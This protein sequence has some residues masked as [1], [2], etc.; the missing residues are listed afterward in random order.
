MTTKVKDAQV[1]KK[2]GGEL[3]KEALSHELTNFKL[4]ASSVASILDPLD[5][6]IEHY[7]LFVSVKDVPKGIRHFNVRGANING[8]LYKKVIADFMDRNK[9]FH[10]NNRGIIILAESVTTRGKTV[11][12]DLGK[13]GGIMDGGRTDKIIQV[14]GADAP[15]NQFV[16]IQIRVG[17]PESKQSG[18]AVGL[19][20]SHQV[21]LESIMNF[22]KKFDDIKNV[23]K[24]Q[25][26]AGDISW[27]ESTKRQFK[28][29]SIE[30]VRCLTALNINIWPV[31][32][33]TIKKKTQLGIV[34]YGVAP[35]AACHGTNDLLKTYEAHIDKYDDLV[36]LLP[37]ILLLRDYIESRAIHIYNQSGDGTKRGGYLPFVGK[38]AKGGQKAIQRFSGNST[39]YTILWSAM[40]PMLG[41]MRPFLRRV[42]GKIVFDGGL[43]GAKKNFESVAYAMIEMLAMKCRGKSIDDARALLLAETKKPDMWVAM[44]NVVLA[45]QNNTS[46]AD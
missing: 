11:T 32:P 27:Q 29:G 10:L 45:N 18:M 9:T 33:Y 31:T 16:F 28:I 36:D 19:N 34:R 21:Q 14:H 39:Y 17:V 42:N 15:E 3:L 20:S 37:Q 38:P 46:K 25:P 22:E 5:N 43:E 35:V 2:D 23:I 40:Y 13:N 8:G 30:L 7:Y 24:D 41:A 4:E 26:Y 1:A 6:S 44:L 12:V